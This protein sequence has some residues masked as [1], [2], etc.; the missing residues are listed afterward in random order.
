MFFDL[1]NFKF[2]YDKWVR[3]SLADFQAGK[4]KEIVKNYPFVVSDDV[5]WTPYLGE[6]SEKT[7]SLVTSGG[8]YLKD[9]Q[10]PFDTKTIHGDTTFRE[11]PRGVRE[12][13]LAIAHPHYDHRLAEEDINTVF[14]LQRFIELEQEGV[15]GKVADSHYSL[16]YVNDVVTLVTKTVPEIIH[17]IKGAEVNLLFLVP[18]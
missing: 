18:V 4:M 9:T 17:R 13:E 8:I 7:I 1:E 2:V 6:A 3:E 10:T 15:V 11:I 5:P 12:K 16:S 14:P